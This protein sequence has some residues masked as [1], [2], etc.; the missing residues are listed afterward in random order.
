MGGLYVLHKNMT[1]LKQLVTCTLLF[2]TIM[3]SNAQSQKDLAYAG[4][5]SEMQKL[6]NSLADWSKTVVAPGAL[7]S[8]DKI[9]LMVASGEPLFKLEDTKKAWLTLSAG[10]IGAKLNSMPSVKFEKIFFTDSEGIQAKEGY[11]CSPELIKKLQKSVS[12]NEISLEEFYAKLIT[13]L[14]EDK[15]K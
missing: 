15:I 3:H 4:A 7:D 5:S 1:K 13:G 11:S 6:I 8:K 14:K 9:G 10:V 2:F 12:S